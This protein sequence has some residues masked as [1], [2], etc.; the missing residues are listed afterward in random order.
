MSAGKFRK[1][2]VEIEARQ[3][4]DDL[5]NHIG[6]VQWIKDGGHDA[7]VSPVGTHI[8]ICT[9]EGNM[10]ADLGDWIIRGVQGEFYPCK[11]DIFA[12]TYERAEADPTDS[13]ITR[14]PRQ[15]SYDE[16]DVEEIVA[17]CVS[18]ARDEERLLWVSYFENWL[19]SVGVEQPTPE[20]MLKAMRSPWRPFDVES[21]DA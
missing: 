6:I 14:S 15:G 20:S 19:A 13:K 11:P 1:K 18:V 4:L 3:M 5:A 2:P 12:A 17:A 10:T 8:T 16:A 21:R 7:F 9:L